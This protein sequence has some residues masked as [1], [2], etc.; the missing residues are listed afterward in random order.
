[1]FLFLLSSAHAFTDEL[2]RM[3][4]PSLNRTLGM[5]A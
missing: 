3:Y 2:L 5:E 4:W 1:M